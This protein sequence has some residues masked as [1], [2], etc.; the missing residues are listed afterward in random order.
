MEP[1]GDIPL[2][3]LWARYIT[4]EHKQKAR[5]RKRKPGA[6]VRHAAWRPAGYLRRGGASSRGSPHRGLNPAQDR[7]LFQTRG[8]GTVHRPC[9][10]ISLN[11][12][13]SRPGS[14]PFPP[15]EH[16]EIVS[17]KSTW[18]ETLPIPALSKSLKL[19]SDD[20]RRT[21]LAFP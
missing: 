4:P 16:F 12:P 6:E 2:F 20:T 21:L 7:L 14:R 8:K 19:Q 5:C 3:A 17:L 15:W 1:A 13:R 18:M 9:L 10:P 11:S